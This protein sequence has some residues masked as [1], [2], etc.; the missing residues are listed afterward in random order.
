MSAPKKASKK[1]PITAA[2]GY[3]RCAKC[4]ALRGDPCR[5]PSGKTRF[6]HDERNAAAERH[7]IPL[8]WRD[9]SRAE[10]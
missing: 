6:P 3:P 7:G 9:G 4:E 2:I 10:P 1:T 8:W 5:T